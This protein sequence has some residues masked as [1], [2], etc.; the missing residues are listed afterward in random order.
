MVSQTALSSLSWFASL[1]GIKG[2]SGEKV[3]AGHRPACAKLR[4]Y[5]TVGGSVNVGGGRPEPIGHCEQGAPGEPGL[6]IIGPRGPPSFGTAVASFALLA[7]GLRTPNGRDSLVLEDFQVFRVNLVQKERRVCVVTI[8]TGADPN[9]LSLSRARPEHRDHRGLLA[10]QEILDRQALVDPLVN[11]ENPANL[12]RTQGV[13]LV[14]LDKRVIVVRWVQVD[15]KAPRVI[16]EIK[17]LREGKEWLGK[18]E[19]KETSLARMPTVSRFSGVKRSHYL[20][21]AVLKE[22]ILSAE[23]TTTF[24]CADECSLYLPGIL[25]NSKECALLVFSLEINAAINHLQPMSVRTLRVLFAL[26]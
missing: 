24:L 12:E 3:S 2:N 9:S 10:P 6:S 20:S 4:I 16:K 26:K 17:A 18:Q 5:L 8:L 14:Y 25:L 19:K 13:S 21:Q 1:Q 23:N 15:L 22:S 7:A 11:Q